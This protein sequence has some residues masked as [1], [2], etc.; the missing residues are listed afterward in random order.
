MKEFGIPEKPINFVKMTLQ[1]TLTQISGKLSGSF[2]STCGLRQGDALS[3]L[4]FKIM[5]EKV[6]RNT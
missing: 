5:L 1:R 6:I 3:T 4:L 2:E